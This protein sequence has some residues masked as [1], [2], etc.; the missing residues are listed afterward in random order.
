MQLY[1]HSATAADS[2]VP[3]SHGRIY[4]I[5]TLYTAIAGML[6]LLALIDSTGRAADE[7][8]AP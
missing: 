5:G 4:D 3:P 6:S 2:R 7:G 8:G 1:L